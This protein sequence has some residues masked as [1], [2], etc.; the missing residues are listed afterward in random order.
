MPIST[1][2]KSNMFSGSIVRRL[3]EESVSLQ[4]KYGAARVFDLTLSSPRSEPPEAFTVELKRLI[5][6]PRPG[7]H[8]YMENAGYTDSRTA[9]AAQ[10]TLE[11]G[12]K[13]NWNEVIMTAGA[14]GALNCALKTLLN[15]REEVIVLTP[16][17]FE[18]RAYIENHGGVCKAV[19]TDRSFQ[20]DIAAM[21][22]A[23]TPQTKAVIINS[24]NDPTGIV[25]SDFIFQRIAETLEKKS[26]E[27]KKRIYVITDDSYNYF[28]YE[29]GKCPSILRHY[30]HTIIVNTYSKV[31]SIPGERLGYVAVYP[32]CEDVKDVAAGLIYTLR[33]LGFVNASAL[34]QNVARSINIA[35]PVAEYRRKRDILCDKLTALG[36]V[37]NKPQGAFYLFVR[38]P[39]TDDIAFVNELKKHLVLTIPGSVFQSPG[40]FRVSYCLDDQILEGSLAGFSMA[41]AKYHK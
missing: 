18:Y 20:P 35:A 11:N 17:N 33:T 16:C 32:E 38:S 37:V 31:L 13:F 8:R 40:Y 5:D 10:L 6:N 1:A 2:L 14:T 29:S 28:Y 19:S 25:Y 34:M 41:L 7:M 4:K 36:Y 24:P 39:E 15:P 3:Y 23:I 21:E 30:A 22:A 12:V 9:V 26:R 27:L